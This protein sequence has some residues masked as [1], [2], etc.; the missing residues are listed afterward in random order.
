MKGGCA[1]FHSVNKEWALFTDQ[2]LHNTG[3]GYQNLQQS[4][5]Q[6]VQLAPRVEV[7]V[8]RELINQVS[9]PPPSD[10]GL[11]ETTQDL[12]DR[13]KYRTPST[14]RYFDRN[15]HAQQCFARTSR[16]DWFL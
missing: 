7:E 11:Y 4:K 3:I 13:W 12:A 16:S 9:E 2:Q 6:K 10:L 8:S 14:K 1:S 5:L 15:L